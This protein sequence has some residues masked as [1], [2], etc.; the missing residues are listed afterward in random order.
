[1]SPETIFSL[2]SATAVFAWLILGTAGFIKSSPT[3]RLLLFVGG[4]VIPL[5]LCVLYTV[6]LWS[7]WGSTPGGNFGSLDGVARLF[8]SPGKLLGG[9]VHYLAFDLLVARW[10]IDDVHESSKTRW[11]L[12]PCLPLVF[13]FG[14]AGL[15]LYFGLKMLI[16]P[17]ILHPAV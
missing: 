2:A 10:I 12:L 5:A 14:P 16:K 7:Y 11:V 4:R 13:M 6:V 8:A 9:W 15:A 1:M 3:H 17:S